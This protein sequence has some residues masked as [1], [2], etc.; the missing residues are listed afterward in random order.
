MCQVVD[1][2]KRAVEKKIRTNCARFVELLRGPAFGTW[3]QVGR[4]VSGSAV[5]ARMAAEKF[6]CQN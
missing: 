3:E 5:L 6:K 2:L 4:V 1:G